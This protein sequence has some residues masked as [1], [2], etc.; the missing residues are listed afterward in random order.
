MRACG[1]NAGGQKGQHGHGGATGVFLCCTTI[2]YLA[3]WAGLF[4]G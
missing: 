4:V 1:L 3:L 2:T